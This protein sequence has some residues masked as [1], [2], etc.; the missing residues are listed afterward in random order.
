MALRIF[1]YSATIPAG[2]PKSAPITVPI[3]LDGWD[4]QRLDLQVPPGPS[5]LMG[6][7]VFNNGVQWFPQSPGEWIVWDDR[8]ESWYPTEQPNGGGWSVVG[9]NTGTYD[10]TVTTIWHVNLPATALPTV[11]TVQITSAPA[12]SPLVLL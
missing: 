9:Y 5:Y 1:Q 3:D 7:A 2:T 4:L 10:H 12:P 6:F 8:A 11:P